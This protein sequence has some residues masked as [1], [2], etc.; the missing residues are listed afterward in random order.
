MLGKRVQIF[1]CEIPTPEHVRQERFYIFFLLNYKKLNFE[2]FQKLELWRALTQWWEVVFIHVFTK[3]DL[4]VY[5]L[6][7][8]TLFLFFEII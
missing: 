2:I 6:L 3:K 5:S 7:F 8:V 4:A 1:V